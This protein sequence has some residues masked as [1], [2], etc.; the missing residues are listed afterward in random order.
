MQSTGQTTFKRQ[1]I[2]MA[3]VKT[4]LSVQFIFGEDCAHYIITILMRI[5][6]KNKI[7]NRKKATE[8]FKDNQSIIIGGFMA[9]GTS[10]VLCDVIGESGIKDYTIIAN[11]TA[12]PGIGIGKLVSTERVAK[13]IA[14]HIGLNP[15]TGALMNSGKMEVLLVPQGTLIEQIRSGGYG[16]G[17]VLTQTGIGTDV[18][19]GK[20]TVEIKGNKFIVEEAIT[21][22]ISVLHATI[23]DTFGNCFFKGTTKNFNVQAG[24]AGKTVIVTA[25]EI[26]S[27]GGLDKEYIHLSGIF[28]DYILEEK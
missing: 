26:V 9:N 4:T 12:M 23:A 25:D 21:A 14:S 13:V 3:S 15:Q 19:K 27:V 28:V 6:M 18:Q 2:C 7:I 20:Q 1:N 24:M 8:I 22:D 11:D 16:L 10:E 5:S 17:G